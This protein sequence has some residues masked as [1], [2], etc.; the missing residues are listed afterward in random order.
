M[1]GNYH[2]EIVCRYWWLKF[3]RGF[4]RFEPLLPETRNLLFIGLDTVEL[5]N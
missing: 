5:F 2:F 3:H 4:Q 1:I